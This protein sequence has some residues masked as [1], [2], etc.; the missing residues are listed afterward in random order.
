MFIELVMN[1]G[2]YFA[3]TISLASTSSNNELTKQVQRTQNAVEDY[4]S[5]SKTVWKTRWEVDTNGTWKWEK[6]IE[7]INIAVISYERLA[8]TDHQDTKVQKCLAFMRKCARSFGSN[9]ESVE[10]WLAI[11]PSSNNYC[12]VLCGALQIIFKTAAKLGTVRDEILEALSE[13]PETIGTIKSYENIYTKSSRMRDSIVRFEVAT[14]MALE[15]A[16]LWLTEK[17]ICRSHHPFKL[18]RA[19]IFHRD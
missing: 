4:K 12:S 1:R 19:Q 8:N 7:D 17:P 13:I 2:Y 9:A 10:N 14:L 18:S 11:I 16:L 5:H 15:H 6:V 3:D